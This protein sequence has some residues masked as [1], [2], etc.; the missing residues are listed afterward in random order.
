MKRIIS[1]V[2]VAV[3][4]GPALPAAAAPSGWQ[5]LAAEGEQVV[6]F[7]PKSVAVVPE[8]LEVVVLEDFRNTEFLGVPVYPHKSR[9]STYRV[10][11]ERGEAGLMAW[12]LYGSNFGQGKVVW[13]DKAEDVAMFRAASEPAVN[14][15]VQRVCAPF[16]ALR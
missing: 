5:L 15:L 9:V 11:C 6:F 14:R 13:S 4:L 16:M 10:D 12:T 7:Q 8:G 2:A 3:A 1:A